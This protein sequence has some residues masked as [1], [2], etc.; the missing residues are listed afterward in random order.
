MPNVKPM[1]I[2][3]WCGFGKPILN[4]FLNPFVSELNDIILHG[5]KINGYALKVGI[6]FFVCDTPARAFLKGE[7][8]IRFFN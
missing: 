8:D 5:I 1:I 4:E 2:S 3:I 6:K 7:N